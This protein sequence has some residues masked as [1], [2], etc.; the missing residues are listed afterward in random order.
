MYEFAGEV[1]L[2][3]KILWLPLD[4]NSKHFSVQLGDIE[5]RIAFAGVQYF[6]GIDISVILDHFQQESSVELNGIPKK[7]LYYRNS[8]KDSIYNKFN[9]SWLLMDKDNQADD[10]AE[11][12]YRYLAQTHPE[13]NTYFILQKSSHDWDRLEKEG[14]DLV[15]F[16]TDEHAAALLRAD[17]FM[18]SHADNYV[19]NYL[20]RKWFRDIIKSKF[21]FLQHGVILHD[22]SAW[23][24]PKYIDCFLTTS[25]L[26]YDSIGGDLSQYKFTK[27]EVVLTGLPRHDT[28]LL[29][30]NYLE[31]MILIMPTWRHYLVG[32][33]VGMGADRKINNNFENTD[34]AQ[35]WKAL[36]HS[37][38]LKKLVQ[39]YGYT[40]IF[41]PHANIQ[42]YLD[43]FDMPEHITMYAHEMYSIQKLFQKAAIMITDY[44][45]VAFEMGVLKR[46]S[47]YYQFDYDM[48]FGGEHTS[49][50]GYFNYQKDGFG[51][52]CYNT[53]DLLN[54][55]EIFLKAGGEMD[56]KYKKRIEEFFAFH[57]TDN[58]KRVLEAIRNLDR[59][60]QGYLP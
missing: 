15:G 20:P 40:V 25:P 43:I 10:N 4:K 2:Y 54:A 18:S 12:F 57:D 60:G 30:K 11:H 34:Y 59:L 35:Y 50:E 53:S 55:L 36:L 58:C 33:Q 49:K 7:Y 17:H 24:N 29:G 19:A 46:G 27:K 32:E 45:S 5:T 52:V 9:N 41:A 44:S 39:S 23:L 14:F 6:D 3:E 37:K 56:Q 48:V 31:K 47:I 13:I 38:R 28:L 42:P 8:Y 16:G 22:L 21:T 51:P 26:E 1:F